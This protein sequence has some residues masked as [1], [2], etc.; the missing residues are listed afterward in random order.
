MTRR[1]KPSSEPFDLERFLPYR[2]AVLSHR[3]ARHFAEVYAS[4]VGL[5]GP[6]WRALAVL[7]L[8]PASLSAVEIARRTTMDPVMTHR[9][10][11]RLAGSGLVARTTDPVDRRR[12]A[13]AMTDAGWAMHARMV[14]LARALEAEVLSSLSG[15]ERAMLGGLLDKLLQVPL[16]PEPELETGPTSRPM[17]RP[18]GRKT[19][20]I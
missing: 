10:L 1:S 20:K 17:G 3:V 5:S 7:G 6:E 11:E 14:P 18:A 2:L 9:A 4:G 19:T 16:R 13:L 8:G 15:D 12:S